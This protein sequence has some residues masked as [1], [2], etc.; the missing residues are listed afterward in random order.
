[1]HLACL[2]DGFGIVDVE[3]RSSAYGNGFEVA[4]VEYEC[5]RDGDGDYHVGGGGARHAAEGPPVEERAD[6]PAGAG[7]TE[8][9][10]ESGREGFGS[11]EGW[12]EGGG[13]AGGE[14]RG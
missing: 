1:M 7:V 13:A 12:W 9:G 5:A 3:A 6:F 4:E 2:A 11:A 8:G 10:V 14:A